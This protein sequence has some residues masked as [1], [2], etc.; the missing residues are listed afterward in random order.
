MAEFTGFPAETLAFL[1]GISPNNTKAWFDAHRPQY[2]AHWMAPARAFVDAAGQA[3]REIAPAVEA[4]PKVNGSIFRIN[5]YI[6]FS[7][8]K[9]PYKDHLDFWFWEGQ[10]K[11]AVSGFYMRITPTQLGI[12]GGAH[13]FDKDHLAAF[14][15]AVVDTRTGAALGD[16]VS[17]LEKGGWPVEGRRYMQLPRGFVAEDDHQERF[18]RHSA[19]RC[20]SDGPIPAS[21]HTRRLVSYAMTRWRKLELLHRW[22]VNTLQ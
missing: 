14:R 9:R 15:R 10:R 4:E 20:N 21:L 5:R 11:A 19:L 8:D 6:R 16:A 3:F 22:L 17:A 7:K 1:E 13:A 18:L 2:D 12:G